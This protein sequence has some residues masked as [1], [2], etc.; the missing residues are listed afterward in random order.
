M[1]FAICLYTVQQSRNWRNVD[2]TSLCHCYVPSWFDAPSAPRP[3]PHHFSKLSGAVHASS[4]THPYSCNFK[5]YKLDLILIFVDQHNRNVY[6]GR[7]LKSEIASWKS[8]CWHKSSGDFR[9]QALRPNRFRPWWPKTLAYC[10]VVGITV[11]RTAV[12]GTAT[13]SP[14]GIRYRPLYFHPVVC[15]SLWSPYIIGQT[16][17]FLPCDFYL[18]SFFLA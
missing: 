1:P 6:L 11:V 13:A 12:V 2:M 18:L 4:K 7:W 14:Y 8:D 16:I 9:E 17:I 3:Q 5:K 15:S 10:P